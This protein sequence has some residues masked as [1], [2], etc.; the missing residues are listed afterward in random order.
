[1][2]QVRV[3][4]ASRRGRLAR[5]GRHVARGDCGRTCSV[6]RR[7]RR[8]A[9]ADRTN[10]C[11]SSSPHSASRTKCSTWF[12]ST[13]CHTTHALP[14]T[15][16]HSLAQLDHLRHSLSLALVYVTMTLAKFC[17]FRKAA[18]PNSVGSKKMPSYHAA[19]K[20]VAKQTVAE[21]SLAELCRFW[22]IAQAQAHKNKNK[23]NWPRCSINTSR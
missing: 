12:T 18:Q 19:C 22:G 8:V 6:A 11:A 16:V 5:S 15:V 3:S 17:K 14:N 13:T 23:T 2:L 9:E 4:R 10:S 21:Q 20:R 1:M 7:A